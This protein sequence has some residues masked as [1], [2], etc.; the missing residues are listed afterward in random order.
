MRASEVCDESYRIRSEQAFLISYNVG[1]PRF[2]KG[3][4]RS[5]AG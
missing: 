2:A 3:G 1:K 5:K 4:S